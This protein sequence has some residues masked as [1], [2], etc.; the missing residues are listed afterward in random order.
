MENDLGLERRADLSELLDLPASYGGAGLQSL[1]SAADEEFLGSFAGI[2]GALI[3]FCMN[4]ELQVYIRIA[5][6]LEGTE[7]EGGTE[8]A[9]ATVKGVKKAFQ[10]TEWLREPLTEEESNTAT[11]LIK[12]IILVETPGAYDPG[13][14]DAIPEPVT[15][16]GP[17]SLGDYVTA[18]CK[19]ECGILKHIRHA[20]QVHRL[21]S[22]LNPTKQSRLRATAG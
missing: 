15:L 19:H 22:T 16:P 3:S 20:K 9:C 14:P 8:S 17:R 13:R 21:L 12:G 18:P 11:E 10:R 5:E 1:V 4:T 2:A 6:A 7:A